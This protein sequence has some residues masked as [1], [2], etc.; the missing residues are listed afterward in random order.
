[1][2]NVKYQPKSSSHTF[3][4]LQ[5]VGPAPLFWHMGFP[6]SG[7]AALHHVG[8]LVILLPTHTYMRFQ[9]TTVVFH[10]RVFTSLL[11]QLCPRFLFPTTPQH[12][13]THK[14]SLS[15]SFNTQFRHYCFHK[16]F[17]WPLCPFFYITLTLLYLQTP[18]L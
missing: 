2:P 9:T 5:Q 8:P 4:C 1:M 10:Q 11:P 14:R 17:L 16:C 12:R 18:V 13:H 15:N 3:L 7:S 6:C